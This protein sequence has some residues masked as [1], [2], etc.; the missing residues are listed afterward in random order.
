MVQTSQ[1]QRKIH[2]KKDE[3]LGESDNLHNGWCGLDNEG[4]KKGRL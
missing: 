3:V 2:R 4:K 1:D